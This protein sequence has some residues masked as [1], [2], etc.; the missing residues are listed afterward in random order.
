MTDIQTA[1]TDDRVLLESLQNESRATKDH[2]A[3]L[4]QDL[5]GLKQMKQSS[6]AALDNIATREGQRESKMVELKNSII[7]LEANASA[8]LSNF[9]ALNT[10]MDALDTNLDDLDTS[11]SDLDS[12]DKEKEGVQKKLAFWYGELMNDRLQNKKRVESAANDLTVNMSKLTN[13]TV[14]KME[15]VVDDLRSRLLE[16]FDVLNR[17]AFFVQN[18]KTQFIIL[19]NPVPKI[20]EKSSS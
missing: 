9:E 19:V 17:Q 20:F 15:G 5:E 13:S 11:V 4:G 3:D 12:R 18:Q 1:M 7:K 16:D 10:T 6:E 14:S 8:L 2:L